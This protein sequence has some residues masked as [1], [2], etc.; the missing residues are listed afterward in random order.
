VNTK[1]TVHEM[2]ISEHD[3]EHGI[4]VEGLPEGG[5]DARVRSGLSNHIRYLRATLEDFNA[6]LL[7]L[8]EHRLII[9]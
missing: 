9:L 7:F 5:V 3:L 8:V 1:L 4:R 6:L 2:L